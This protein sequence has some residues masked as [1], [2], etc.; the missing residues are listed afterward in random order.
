MIIV[1]LIGRLGNQLFQ[2]AFALSEQKRLR[3]YAVIDDREQPDVLSRYFSIKGIYRHTLIKK[4][5]LRFHRLPIVYQDGAEDPAVFFSANA[6]N[7]RYYYAYFQSER[8]FTTILDEL[9]SRISIKEEHQLAFQEKYG[10]LFRNNKILAIHN[11]FGDYL[12]WDKEGLGGPGFSLPAEYYKNALAQIPDLDDYLVVVVTD[13]AGLCD[14]Q[15]SFLKKKLIV[16]DSE[17]LDFQVLL[18][19]DR[20]IIAN[21]SFSWWAA[22]LNRK[23]AQVLAPEYWLGFKIRSE[24]P[25]NIIPPSFTKV[26]F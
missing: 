20:L 8:Y 12:H 14:Q 21:S 4:L 3:T 26:K 10:E 18:N 1:K 17:I 25:N 7:R 19:A 23:N 16:S 11:R 2:Y 13:D 15:M 9:R 22:Y 5:V 6:R 24:F